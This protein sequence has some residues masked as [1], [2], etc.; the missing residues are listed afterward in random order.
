MNTLEKQWNHAY[1]TQKTEVT[2][3]GVTQ[4]VVF[5]KYDDT[6]TVKNRMKIFYPKDS[7]LDV[8]KLFVY[9]NAYYLIVNKET[10]ENDIYYKSEVHKA[11]FT[12]PKLG[13][14][15]DLHC[16]VNT[17][18]LESSV[19][20]SNSVMTIET[21]QVELW[22]SSES[23]VVAPMSSP[24]LGK[25]YWNGR[26]QEIKVVNTYQDKGIFRIYAELATLTTGTDLYNLS[27]TSNIKASYNLD[28]VPAIQSEWIPKSNGKTITCQTLEFTSSDE[29][30]A[31]IDRDGVITFLSTGDVTFIVYW[32][33]MNFS[34]TVSVN[35]SDNSSYILK[36]NGLNTYEYS[37]SANTM[38][39]S[40]TP[41]DGVSDTTGTLTY[42]SSNPQIAT[43]SDAGLLTMIGEGSV[44]ITCKWNEYNVANTQTIVVTKKASVVS[45]YWKITYKTD[46]LIRVGSKKKLTATYYDS[47]NAETVPTDYT[48]TFSIENYTPTSKES[49][50]R[51]EVQYTYTTTPTT[52]YNYVSIS[53][54]N[55]TYIGDTFDVV[56]TP[57]DGLAP[58]RQSVSIV[59]LYE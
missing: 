6:N 22:T 13:N 33:E 21:G 14:Y 59:S 36:Y 43:I 5:R 34:S 17:S 49:A 24:V 20:A 30:K 56:W 23:I 57:N 58:C 40:W 47:A 25:F 52:A 28:E 3:K 15:Y 31:I 9:K 29:S 8:G 11:D 7:L 32:K 45:N 18:G 1:R 26:Y 37:D 46:P 44:D 16:V 19:S 51:S 35:I 55:N 48:G 10:D 27:I 4:Y 53:I 12:I 42:T 2:Y 54:D 38:Q 39:L 50:F 41:N